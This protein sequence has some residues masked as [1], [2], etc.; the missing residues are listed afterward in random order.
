MTVVAIS[1]DQSLNSD[2][3]PMPSTVRFNHR[4]RRR[5]G[6]LLVLVSFVSGRSLMCWVTIWI[7][8]PQSKEKNQAEQAFRAIEWK[9]NYLLPFRFG[10]HL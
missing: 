8:A 1:C 4:S 7:P 5:G 9:E 3:N 6:P 10:G 2:A